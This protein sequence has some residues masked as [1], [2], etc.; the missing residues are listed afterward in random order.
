M[1]RVG[2]KMKNEKGAWGVGGWKMGSRESRRGGGMQHFSFVPP[3]V[4]L[5]PSSKAPTRGTLFNSF[6][7]NEKSGKNSFWM[8]ALSLQIL[9]SGQ[10]AWWTLGAWGSVSACLPACKAVSAASQVTACQPDSTQYSLHCLYEVYTLHILKVK[11]EWLPL[12]L[13]N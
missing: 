3:S 9:S 8:T 13:H 11:I 12:R 6:Y 5:S 1:S 10:R 4:W 7:D 2:R